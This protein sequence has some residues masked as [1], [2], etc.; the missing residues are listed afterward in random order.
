M[1]YME[2]VGAVASTGFGLP[3]WLPPS[4]MDWALMGVLCFTEVFG[5]LL[6]NR[7]LEYAPAAVLEPFN[8]TL[9]VFAT[10]SDCWSS[11]TSR[12]P[13]QLRAQP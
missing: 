6:L 2:V 11:E 12:M 9:L 8:Y 10:Q 1:L 3:A 4:P 13:G 5:H 7:A